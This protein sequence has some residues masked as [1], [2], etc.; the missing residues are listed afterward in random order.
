MQSLNK[1]NV[2]FESPIMPLLNSSLQYSIFS[3]PLFST[4]L[5]NWNIMVSQIPCRVHSSSCFSS[6]HY[7]LYPTREAEAIPSTAWCLYAGAFP[8]PVLARAA[9]KSGGDQKAMNERPEG[10][11]WHCEIMLVRA[12]LKFLSMRSS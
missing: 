10:S 1:R 4:V 6:H 3:C 8:L 2:R 5:N 11:T 12:G 7:L 9:V